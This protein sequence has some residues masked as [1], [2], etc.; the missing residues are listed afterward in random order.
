VRF[1]GLGDGYDHDYS[2]AELRSWARYLE[3][4][5]S[6][7]AF[8]NNDGL[9]RAF[10]DAT[11]P[12]AAAPRRFA[13]IRA[14]YAGTRGNG[15][16]MTT[17]EA[18]RGSTDELDPLLLF[19]AEIGRYPLLTPSEEVRLAKRMEAGDDR[20]KE[21]MTNCNLRLVVSVAKRY[22][23][24]GLPLIDLVQEGCLGLIRA[25]EKFDWRQGCRFSTYATW[26]IRQAIQ[27]GVANSAPGIR[28]PLHIVERRRQ[29][30]AAEARLALELGR[31][32]TES[33]L[34]SRTGLPPLA[35]R[36]LREPTRVV[37]SLDTSADE[38]S[39]QLGVVEPYAVPGGQLPEAARDQAVELAL[40]RLPPRQREVLS[41]RYGL[42][43]GDGLPLRA[44][45]E[46]LGITRA[47]VRQIEL[48]ALARLAAM[49]EL[50][51]SRE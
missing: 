10:P 29:L 5:E 40:R 28:L 39:R 24:H 8:F 34:A 41:L 4:V 32:P 38:A 20:A 45:G 11:R 14:G 49:P 6:G 12:R 16:P 3:R 36:D 13:A 22:Q 48:A 15:S 37:A 26:W 33:E 19:L 21:R 46:V 44:I 25:V 27:R 47:R 18:H 43:G 2:A 23:G 7:F 30:A 1:H 17:V 9:A 50:A 31:E 35:I 42:N 51:S